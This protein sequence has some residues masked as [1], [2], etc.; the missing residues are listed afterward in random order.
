MKL[1]LIFLKNC[2]YI[3]ETLSNFHVTFSLFFHG[4][5]QFSPSSSVIS[6]S[7]TQLSD[8]A[9]LQSLQDRS[10]AATVTASHRPLLHLRD[11]H[12]FLERLIFSFR[13]S[14]S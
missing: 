13:S 2:K 1:P 9:T 6:L 5:S 7:E 11:S 14:L 12:L 8:G 3:L 4:S 10:P